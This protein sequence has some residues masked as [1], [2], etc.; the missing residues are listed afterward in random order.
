MPRIMSIIEARSKL[1]RLPELL[2]RDTETDAVE[3]TRRG[4]PV[5]A[6]MPWELYEALVETLEVLSDEKLMKA[7]RKGVRE[8]RQGKGIPWKRARQELSL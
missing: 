7:L 3:V 4:K 8:I 5:L 2:H 1:T 6:V